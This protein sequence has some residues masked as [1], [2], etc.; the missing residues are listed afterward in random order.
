[1]PEKKVFGKQKKNIIK[2]FFDKFYI[3]RMI[4]V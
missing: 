1:M 4:Q 3:K 2:Q